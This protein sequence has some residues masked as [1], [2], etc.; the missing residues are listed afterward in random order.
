MTD[1]PSRS[2]ST[3]APELTDLYEATDELLNASQSI[4]SIRLEMDGI[5]F[6][7]DQPFFWLGIH[8]DHKVMLM[9][10]YRKIHE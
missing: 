3:N 2:S 1:R 10:E 5:P 7:C 4:L 6:N 8:G 9:A